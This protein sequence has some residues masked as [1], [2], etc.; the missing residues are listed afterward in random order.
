MTS[1]WPPFTATTA[2][3]WGNPTLPSFLTVNILLGTPYIR[4]V[5]TGQI[6]TDQQQIVARAYPPTAGT[7]MVAPVDQ[8][9]W[10][11]SS[12]AEYSGWTYQTQLVYYND[13]EPSHD[14]IL[15][16]YV[17]PI[18]GQS[19]VDLDAAP[20][21]SPGVP[22][23]IPAHV[24][25]S[26]NGEYGDVIYSGGGGSSAVPINVPFSNVSSLSYVHGLGRIPSVSFVDQNNV[27]YWTDYEPSLTTVNATFP[28]PSTGIMI[29]S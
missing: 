29:L 28:G 18:V 27:P 16:N 19:S 12:G 24:V 13:N 2:L 14:T 25:T 3:T 22:V 6:V 21:G 9:G 20:Q 8:P 1:I 7:I 4:H 23:V 26:F 5:A 17:Q 11:D 15:S 10:V